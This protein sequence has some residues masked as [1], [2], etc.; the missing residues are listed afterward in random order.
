MDVSTAADKQAGVVRLSCG[1]II[2]PPDRGGPLR[3]LVA[4]AEMRPMLKQ[5]EETQKALEF[6]VRA[7]RSRAEAARLAV[8]VHVRR[9]SRRP[10]TKAGREAA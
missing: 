4:C 5:Y 7:S 3:I 6:G 8:V 10:K 9:E 2:D 1:C